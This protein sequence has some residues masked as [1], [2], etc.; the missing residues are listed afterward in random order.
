MLVMGQGLVTN[1]SCVEMVELESKVSGTAQEDEAVEI[2]DGIVE[3]ITEASMPQDYQ[4]GEDEGSI[5]A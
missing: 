2:D 1:Q 3:M 4:R 5:Y